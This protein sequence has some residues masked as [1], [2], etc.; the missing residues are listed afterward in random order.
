MSEEEAARILGPFL[1][2]ILR[3]LP[4]PPISTVEHVELLVRLLTGHG[5]ETERTPLFWPA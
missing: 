3:G 5:P 4:T 1:T 2:A